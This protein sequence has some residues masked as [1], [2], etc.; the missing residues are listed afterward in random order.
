MPWCEECARYFTPSAMNDDGTCPSC[1]P[2]RRGAKVASTITAK[3]LNLRKL[4]VG[5]G[6]DED[7]AKAPWHFK[8]LLVML[9]AYLA[10][11]FVEIF[12]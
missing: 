11:R 6:G 5:E 3:N 10:W 1:G 8:V 12:V 2:P 4:A 7:D 9:V